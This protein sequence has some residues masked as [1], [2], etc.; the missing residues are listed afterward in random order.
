M[1]LSPTSLPSAAQASAAYA[2]SKAN[3]AGRGGPPSSNGTLQKL[4]QNAQD[5]E[6]VFLEN[7]NLG[8][9][10]VQFMIERA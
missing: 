8:E 5:F 1:D 7:R 4:W 2:N 9:N 3:A 6:T 10:D